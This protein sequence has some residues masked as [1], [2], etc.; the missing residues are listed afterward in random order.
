MNRREL[1]KIGALVMGGA[2]SGSLSRNVMAGILP[3][4]KPSRDVFV[5]NAKQMISTL[6]EMIIP[7]TD[8]PG[9]IE[10]GVPQ[11]IEMMV[12]DWYTDNERKI[13]F[14]GLAALD[15]FC[16]DKYQAPFLQCSDAQRVEA[17]KAAEKLAQSYRSSTASPIDFAMKKVDENT[18]FFTK[19]KELTV[20]GYYTSE[21][22]AKQELSYNP[23]PMRY[24]GDYDFAKVGRQWSW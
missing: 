2:L 18:P 1:M 19:I 17:L 4:D 13:L 22:G 15:S 12:A 14:D 8:T 6:A 9:A 5:A 3:T 7:K 20:V 21:V 24:E 11:F 16:R 10:A 23:M